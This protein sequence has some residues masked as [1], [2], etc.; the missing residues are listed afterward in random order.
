MT[1]VNHSGQTLWPGSTV[2]ADQPV[3]FA[4]LPTLA[5]GQPATV[6]VPETSAPGHWRGKFFARQGCTGTSGQD[7]HCT[8]GDCGAH[9]D[10]CTTGEQPASLA[11]FNFDTADGLATVPPGSASCGTAGCPENLLPH[12]PA[13]NR[14]HSPGGTLINCINP[15]R[16]APTSYSNAIKTHCPKAYTWSKQ[17][18]EPSNQT[19]YQCASCTGSTITFHSGS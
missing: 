18:T 11:E 17:D 6:T 15:N 4:S 1:F 19:T 12:C 13:E 5:D 14:Q 10:H 9:T 3:N 8:V 2:N 16:D 7:F